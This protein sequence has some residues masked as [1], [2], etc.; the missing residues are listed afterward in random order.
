MTKRPLLLLAS[1][2]FLVAGLG[3]G[4]DTAYAYFTSSGSGSGSASVTTLKNVTLATATGT[5]SAKLLPGGTG[6]MTLTV[7]NQNN[8]D[9]TL[10]EVAP[11]GLVTASGTSGCVI[12]ASARPTRALPRCPS[13][14]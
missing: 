11:D 4:A 9:V 3:L 5:V 13:R 8:F 10:V 12:T 14:P 2:G 6:D 1:A 7:N